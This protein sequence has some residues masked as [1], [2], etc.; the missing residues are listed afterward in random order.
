MPRQSQEVVFNRGDLGDISR[1]SDVGML[2]Q[3]MYT[4]PGEERSYR[5]GGFSGRPL[6]GVEL[7]NGTAGD[8]CIVCPRDMPSDVEFRAKPQETYSLQLT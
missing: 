5:Q 4:L 3:S 8:F 7:P 1:V 6:K 2:S